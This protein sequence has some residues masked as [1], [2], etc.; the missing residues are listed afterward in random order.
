MLTSIKLNKIIFNWNSF[1]FKCFHSRKCSWVD[2][3]S[4]RASNAKLWWFICCWNGQAV[5]QRVPWPV[6]WDSLLFTVTK[7]T[8]LVEELYLDEVVQ[9]GHDCSAM[10]WDLRCSNHRFVPEMCKQRLVL[11]C[12][13]SGAWRGHARPSDWYNVFDQINICIPSLKWKWHHFDN[14]FFT[15]CTSGAVSE[16][17]LVKMMIF[18]FWWYHLEFCLKNEPLLTCCYEV[19]LGGFKWKMCSEGPKWNS[20]AFML[21]LSHNQ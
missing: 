12:V 19:D 6:I 17:N 8:S 10:E 7:M 13:T 3:Y 11:H 18:P 2:F 15:D 20:V 16:G 14:I 5:E 1:K 4:Q 9:I 21:V